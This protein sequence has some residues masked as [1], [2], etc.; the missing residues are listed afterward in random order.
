LEAAGYLRR[1]IVPP[2]CVHNGHMYYILLPDAAQRQRMANLLG[3]NGIRA[4]SH[5][6][7]LHSSPAGRR[8]G[9]CH[10]DVRTTDDVWERILRLPL[11]PGLSPS[12]QE[13]VLQTIETIARQR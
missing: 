4:T 7:P 13:R 6:V 2:E 1:Q 3:Q 10:G 8:Y 5:Y 12:E 9:R 11:A